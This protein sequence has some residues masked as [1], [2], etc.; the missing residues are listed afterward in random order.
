MIKNAKP[1]FRWQIITVDLIL[2]VFDLK[3]ID[4]AINLLQEVYFPLS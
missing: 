1:E 4:D 3:N 2:M